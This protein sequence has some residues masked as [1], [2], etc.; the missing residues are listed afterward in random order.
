[1]KREKTNNLITYLISMGL[2]AIIF[3]GVLFCVGNYPFGDKNFTIWDM[4][5][6]YLDFFAW[7]KRVFN[8]D[9][10]LTYSFGKSLGDNTIGLFAYYVSSP[11]N[12]LLIFFDNIQL[13]V[14]VLFATKIAFCG[15]TCSVY[16]RKRFD[17]IKPVFVVLLSVSYALMSYNLK[18]MTN[19]MWLDGAVFLPLMMLGVYRLVSED[20][21]ILLYVA[22]A[23]AI[24]AN[25]YTAYMSCL[26]SA[27]YFIYEIILKK[28]FKIKNEI[29]DYFITFIKYCATMILSV[30]S[31]MFFFLPMALQLLQGKGIENGKEFAI[32]FRCSILDILKALMPAYA[33]TQNSDILILFCGTLTVIG[34]ILFFITRNISI[35]QK[36]FTA[37]MLVI[38][39]VSDVFV[40]TEKIWNGF[41]KVASY[42]S[43]SAFVICFFM[44][45]IAA[46]YFN[47][48]KNIKY[49]KIISIF[50]SMLVVVELFYNA[51]IYMTD[52]SRRDASVYN[53]YRNMA[54]E[55]VSVLKENDDSAF[56]RIEQTSSRVK[57]PKNYLGDF[58]EGMAYGF[59]Q[60]SSYSST[61][62]GSVMDLYVKCGYSECSRIIMFNEP[63]LLSDSLLGIKYLLSKEQPLAYEK[64]DISGKYNDKK[65]YE[66]PYAL[67]LGYMT[68]RSVFKKIK[69]SNSFEY[70][71]KLLSAIVGR[72]VECFKPVKSEMKM[73]DNKV[74]WTMNSPKCENVL[75]GYLTRRG[76]N[77]VDLYVNGK[78]RTDYSQWSS[79]KTVQISDDAKGKE[80]AVSMEGK[81]V[82]MDGI[83]GVFYYLDIKE[84]KKVMEELKV[85]SFYPDNLK[86]GYVE[87]DYI[88]S[89]DGKL[90]MTVPFDRGWKIQCNGK[91]IKAK[92]A[93]G[94]FTVIPVKQGKNHITMTYVTPG[95]KKGVVISIFG[96]AC[97]VIWQILESKKK[98]VKENV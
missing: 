31:V 28:E 23:L 52:Y 63:I 56:Y 24:I 3:V 96:I 10:S 6:Q 9:A 38:L 79:Y 83:K 87:G 35:K 1:M 98:R 20:K 66:N 75:Y 13:F 14:V 40:P 5:Y 46:T 53:N 47:L 44:V 50:L 51:S 72:D 73:E 33:D 22:T 86:D 19:I 68:D 82:K 90:L 62:N 42:Y 59:S 49:L 64:T 97:F 58:N 69:A 25:W 61:Y 32:E 57:K 7:L 67:G 80:Q 74:T 18:Q 45:I 65:V 81:I 93:Q 91:K 89:E 27:F 30:F 21:K 15:L 84:F 29:K 8:G 12:L 17:N 85:K 55:Q 26:F 41:R 37:A 76:A 78:L 16:L 71:N 92:S 4:D 70:Q 88:A 43:R 11:F 36:I 39:V 77:K 60:L 54:K 95:L 48:K 2:P 94:V 34:I